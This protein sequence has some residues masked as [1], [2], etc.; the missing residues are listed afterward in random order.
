MNAQNLLA[1]CLASGQMSAAQANAHLAAGDL[2]E[3]E[4]P[5]GEPTDAQLDAAIYEIDAVMNG[6]IE[7]ATLV[8]AFM[9]MHLESMR[10]IIRKLYAR[11]PI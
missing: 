3:V 6:G 11:P 1:Q 4:V 5:A 7:D 10:A 2:P 9:P 8:P